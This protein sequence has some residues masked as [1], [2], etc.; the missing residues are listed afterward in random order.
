MDNVITGLGRASSGMDLSRKKELPRS[1]RT[2]TH[3]GQGI[4]GLGMAL[5][6]GRKCE[7]MG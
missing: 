1:L 7:G 4:A 2:G 5:T 3:S 6:A